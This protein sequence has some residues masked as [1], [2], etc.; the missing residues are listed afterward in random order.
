MSYLHNTVLLPKLSYRSQVTSL[1]TYNC[2]KISSPFIIM[3]KQKSKLSS[4][5]P[6]VGLFSPHLHNIIELSSY[7][8]RDQ[9]STLYNLLN[10]R[11]SI[12]TLYL[13]CLKSLQST[14]WLPISPLDLVDWSPFIRLVK[15]INNDFLAQTLIAARLLSISFSSSLPSINL[16]VTGGHF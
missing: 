16:T 14:L 8:L 2:Q 4:G 11:S 5:F 3:F 12:R 15:C 10:S 13:A 1:S 7:L 6:N 9:I